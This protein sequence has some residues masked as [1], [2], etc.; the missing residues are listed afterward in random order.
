MKSIRH[1]ILLSAVLVLSIGFTWKTGLIESSAKSL[2]AFV[3]ER[4][5]EDKSPIQLPS[6]SQVVFGSFP[7]PSLK[8]NREYSIFLPPSY[9]KS[10]KS[11]PVVYF[12][13]GLNNDHTSWIVDRYGH[14]HQA[15][16]LL[17]L[18]KKIPEILM[19]H[20]KGD[21][22]FYT[23][24]LD[25]SKR[26]ED[27]IDQDLIQYVEKNY[28]AKTG[29]KWRAIGGTSMGGFGALKIAFKH[30]DLYSATAAHSPIVFLN[31]PEHMSEE[32]KNSGR[33]NWFTQMIAPIFGNP[34]DLNKWRDNN[35]L[36]L[37]KTADLTGLRI[38]FDYGTADRYNAIMGLGQGVKALDV[39]LTNRR[40][41]HAFV[42]HPNEPHGWEL[43]SLHLSESLP[44]L[45]QGFAE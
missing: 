17:I 13:H 40:V 30:K 15:V 28:R 3:D 29:P 45:C 21:N 4:P 20:P 39:V 43:V 6:G 36:D 18:D 1:W 24:Y 11:Y 38:Y 25:G 27:Y 5:L 23:N 35:P 9:H 41:P 44:F 42:E 2:T 16:D 32:T 19:V 12:L 22:S 37:A 26:Y 7:S 14:L 8:E 34:V 10:R 31:E 33:F